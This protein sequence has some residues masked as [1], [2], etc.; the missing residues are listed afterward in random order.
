V[1]D[2][3][4][5]TKNAGYVN[6][7]LTVSKKAVPSHSVGKAKQNV[8]WDEEKKLAMGT[9]APVA[10]DH[11][12]KILQQN[13]F[14]GKHALGYDVKVT[15]K[16]IKITPGP[17]DYRKINYSTSTGVAGSA[18][19]RITHN[20]SLNTGGLKRPELMSHKDL[21]LLKSY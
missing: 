18:V 1:Y 5:N 2:Y 13:R 12:D 21:L 16:R 10:Y 8:L 3:A 9:P 14:E 15:Q 20:H 11:N 4:S 7:E 6:P 17:S 19:N